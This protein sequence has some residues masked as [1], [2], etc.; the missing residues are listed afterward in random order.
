MVVVTQ[1]VPSKTLWDWLQLLGILAIPVV[2]AVG[3]FLFTQQ[4]K[5]QADQNKL[6]QTR[7]TLRNTY[8]DRMSDLL[9]PTNT[10]QPTLDKSRRGDEIRT[11]ARAR[12]LDVL[13]RLDGTRKG[14][15]LQFLHEAHLIGD[16]PPNTEVQVPAIL[17]L[18][19]ADLRK[20]N[21]HR[22]VLRGADLHD[23]DLRDADLR[24]ADMVKAD[25]HEAKLCGAKLCGAKLC[26]ADLSGADLS[27]ADL[28]NANLTNANLSPTHMGHDPGR[29]QKLWSCLRLKPSWQRP[30]P[31][32]RPQKSGAPRDPDTETCTNLTK[33]NLTDADLTGADLTKAKL[34]G[35]DLSRAVGKTKEQLKKEAESLE[36]ATLPDGCKYVKEPVQKS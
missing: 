28:S 30:N 4:Q 9:L 31:E 29:T 36:G 7:E 2:V 34:A 32:G 35:A 16:F 10:H 33:A 25:L 26:G 15:V 3:G 12:T 24:E 22:V 17:D 14:Q 23:T 27:G 13:G 6:D 11:V 8:I 1:Y 5:Q 20:A 18:H 19:Q 21:L